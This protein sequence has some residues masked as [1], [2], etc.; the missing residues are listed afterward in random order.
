MHA[1]GVC[2][3]DMC[4]RVRVKRYHHRTI[5]MHVV[6]KFIRS[7]RIAQIVQCVEG[8]KVEVIIRCLTSFI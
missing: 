6:A 4:L 5:Y 8:F 7:Y 3:Y 1:D 2:F